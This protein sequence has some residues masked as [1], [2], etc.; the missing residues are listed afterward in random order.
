MNL[1]GKEITQKRKDNREKNES[2]RN[3]GRM[4][5]CIVSYDIMNIACPTE[6][7]K[8]MSIRLMRTSKMSESLS[9]C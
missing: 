9:T 7:G 5:E 6:D 4:V 8:R 1:R 2:V 3:K